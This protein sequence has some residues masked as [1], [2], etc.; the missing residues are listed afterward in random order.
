MKALARTYTYRVGID[1]TYY[2]LLS[3]VLNVKM[4]L[5]ILYVKYQCLGLQQNHHEAKCTSV[6]LVL[7]MEFST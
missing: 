3:T 6:F 2:C 1:K 4:L 5:E 7:I